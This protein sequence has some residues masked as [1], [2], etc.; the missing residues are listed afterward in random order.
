[1]ASGDTDRNAMKQFKTQL[2]KAHDMK[3]YNRQH[4]KEEIKNARLKTQDKYYKLTSKPC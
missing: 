1:M 2:T 3:T 4:M